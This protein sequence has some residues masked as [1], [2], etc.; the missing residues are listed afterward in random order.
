MPIYRKINLLA[1]LL[2]LALSG[3]EKET[4]V[5]LSAKNPQLV[6]LGEF[7][8]QDDA[9]INLSTS[10][11]SA[12]A[13]GFPNVEDAQISLLDQN[14]TL[15]EKYLYMGKGN[16]MGK[17]AIAGKNY[18][19][20]VAYQGK[21]YQAETTIPPAFQLNLLEQDST[22]MEA[23]I[24]DLSTEPNF[25]TFELRANRYT[26]DRYYLANGQKVKV[27]SEAEFTALLKINPALVL[28]R[29]TTFDAKFDRLFITTDD[30][31]TENVRFNVL[32]DHSGRIFLT[33]KT[34]NGNKTTLEIDYDQ[35]T[36]KAENMRYTLVVKSTSAAYFN[37][38]YSIDLQAAKSIV[39]VLDVPVKGNISDAFGIWGAAYIQKIIIKK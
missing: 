29:D 6:L 31:R 18:K 36:L 27:N 32:K 26:V 34:F 33:D 37:Y 3:C 14:N 1:L 23:E 13:A 8:Q 16:Y 15:I 7:N 2:F 35:S 30:N 24:V 19:L 28:Q 20:S 9:L 12:A 11:F 25:Y 22:Y 21:T 5:E 4:N 10:V 39:G 17:K 38:L